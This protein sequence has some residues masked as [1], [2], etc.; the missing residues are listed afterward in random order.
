MPSNSQFLIIA[1]G[2]KVSL[3]RLLSLAKKA[4]KIIALDGAAQAL[5]HFYQRQVLPNVILGD[6]DSADPSA[7]KFFSTEAQ[8]IAEII[9]VESQ[10]STDLQKGIHY[11]DQHGAKSI[12][13]VNAL[14]T[15]RLDHTLANMSTL[16]KYYRPDRPIV[17]YTER[18]TLRF[19]RDS[20]LQL[21][22]KI[23]AAAGFFGFPEARGTTS[24]LTW[25]LNHHRLELGNFQSSS[26]YL[27]QEVIDIEIE[28]DAILSFPENIS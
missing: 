12:S 7:L 20:S 15:T 23:G 19:L 16:K 27:A 3:K 22:G 25:D 8:I 9:R 1:N 11:C 6:F 14:G 18:E 2:K 5:N 28:G 10:D 21:R 24:G 17:I 26:N 13:I 4:N